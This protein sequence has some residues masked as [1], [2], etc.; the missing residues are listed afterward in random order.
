MIFRKYIIRHKF[1][2]Y[3]YAGLVHA[4]LYELAESLASSEDFDYFHHFTVFV[5]EGLLK[6]KSLVELE[7]TF[8]L[9]DR[10][11]NSCDRN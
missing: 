5:V 3:L 11:E 2:N 1:S 9:L 10:V 8:K 4:T 7:E 6:N